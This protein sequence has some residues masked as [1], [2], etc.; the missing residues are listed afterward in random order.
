MYFPSGEYTGPAVESWVRAGN[1]LWLCAARHRHEKQIAVRRSRFHLVRHG[2]K[3]NLRPIRRERDVLRPAALIRWHIVVRT[4]RQIA[5]FP[6]NRCCPAIRRR[7]Q[8]EQVPALAVVPVRPVPVQQ[9]RRNVRFHF[10]FFFRVVALFIARVVLAI[11][12]HRRREQQRLPIGRPLHNVYARRNVGPLA[13]LATSQRQHVNLGVAIARRQKRDA[14]PVR[15]PHRRIVVPALRQHHRCASSGRDH[16]DVA[17][18]AIRVD[19]RRC[20]GVHNRFPVW[21]NLRF[22]DA[23][24]SQQTIHRQR[25]ARLRRR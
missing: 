6:R 20:H 13:R 12:I 4:R 10:V 16:P 22:A 5:R 23:M 9:F 11:R 8:H 7:T 1:P 17:R 15:R 19:V 18:V 3:A 2:R 21:G 24:H 14:L 25:L